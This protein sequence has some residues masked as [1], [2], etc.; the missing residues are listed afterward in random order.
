MPEQ[1]SPHQQALIEQLSAYLDGE[2]DAAASREVESLLARD[3]VARRE[4]QRLERA[5]ELLDEL[6][7]AEVSGGFTRNTVEMIAVH[8]AE[9]FQQQGSPVLRWMLPLGAGACVVIAACFGF[10][11]TREWLDR[12]NEQLVRDLPVIER[13]DAYRQLDDVE[14]LRQLRKEGLFTGQEVSRVP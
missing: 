9:Q 6:P 10:M 13:L 4:L 3:D 7:R 8:E 2:L 11:A 14:F 1:A 12:D 5:W